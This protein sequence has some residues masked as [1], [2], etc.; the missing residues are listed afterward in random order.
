MGTTSDTGEERRIG[1]GA[2]GV[3]G[4]VRPPEQLSIEA[5]TRW[6]AIDLLRRL[7]ALRTSR[8]YMIQSAPDRWLVCA[9]P[10]ARS[11]RVYLELEQCIDA[12]RADRG[13]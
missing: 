8:T 11:K 13:L 12:W 10:H 5:R 6:D 3:A 9:R 2:E 7:H 4:V 1:D